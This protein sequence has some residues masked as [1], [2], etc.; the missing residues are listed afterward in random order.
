MHKSSIRAQTGFGVTFYRIVC[1]SVD[2]RPF[3]PRNNSILWIH[4]IQTPGSLRRDVGL[5]GKKKTQLDHKRS[6][7]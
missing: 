3:G 5:Q 1:V 6:L 2:L 4:I 7:P